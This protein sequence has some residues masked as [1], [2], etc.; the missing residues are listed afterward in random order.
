MQVYSLVTRKL[1]LEEVVWSGLYFVQGVCAEDF[2][3]G[4]CV[5][6]YAIDVENYPLYEPHAVGARVARFIELGHLKRNGTLLFDDGKELK[7]TTLD[8]KVR[9]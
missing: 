4:T 5:T 2:V 3:V 1:G 7:S 6:L 9:A 8:G